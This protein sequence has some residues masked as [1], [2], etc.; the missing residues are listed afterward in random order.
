MQ[1]KSFI[2]IALSSLL[3]ITLGRAQEIESEVEFIY[4]K[5]KY[6]HDT[7]RHDDAI[8][9]FN[10][11]IKENPSYENALVYRAASKYALAAYKGAEMDALEY[12]QLKGITPEVTN[13]LAKAQ[14]A[15]NLNVAARNSLIASIRL[16]PN[17]AEPLELL[18]QVAYDESEDDEACEYW[19][20]A[21]RLGST[22][23]AEKLER[24][25]KH[26]ATP[27]K[28]VTVPIVT[29]DEKSQEE[30]DDIPVEEKSDDVISIGTKLEETKNETTKPETK[31]G[32]E[33]SAE[34]SQDSVVVVSDPD[35]SEADHVEIETAPL[36]DP[37]EPAK[38]TI[39][40]DTPNDIVIDED[41]TITIYG[42]ALGKRQLINTPNILML[43]ESDGKVVID[44]CVN[45]QGRIET[46]SYNAK[47]STIE[48]KSLIS[49]ALRKSKDFWFEPNDK[50]QCGHIVYNVK[51]S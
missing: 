39:V 42:Q 24:H 15:L 29:D 30:A 22:K 34:S 43:S 23:A 10:K 18:A 2:L 51:G 27:V 19:S 49:L 17:A 40:D 48:K 12:I 41:L 46:T 13:I 14:L 44:I 8:R 1:A 50:E 45:K 20:N 5:A 11:V 16:S 35:L 9:E 25:C 31:E 47:E 36:R 3:F 38:E 21:A 28:K 37:N 4:I 33:S 7:D 32:N 26:L 6:L